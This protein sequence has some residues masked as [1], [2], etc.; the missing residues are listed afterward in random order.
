MPI[1]IAILHLSMSNL[2]HLI[3]FLWAIPN[4]KTLYTL[5]KV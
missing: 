5:V 3:Q 4:L 1:H 2:F